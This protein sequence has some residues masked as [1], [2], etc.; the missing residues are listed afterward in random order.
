MGTDRL[1]NHYPQ[2]SLI[3]MVILEQGLAGKYALWLDGSEP[4][5][6]VVRHL[7]M[8]PQLDELQ[9]PEELRR[10]YELLDYRSRL[11]MSKGELWRHLLPAYIENELLCRETQ[12]EEIKAFV[13]K[14]PGISAAKSILT[15]GPRSAL[16]RKRETYTQ[17]IILCDG[18]DLSAA[19]AAVSGLPK[20]L[21]FGLSEPEHFDD[22]IRFE[23]ECREFLLE[24]TETWYRSG[25]YEELL[26]RTEAESYRILP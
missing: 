24:I 1:F 15:A 10:K 12:P 16:E 14:P 23:R 6:Y 18:N 19:R 5:A 26:A 13:L 20:E 11:K 4:A 25:E 22:Y 7:T 9:I 21:Y 2:Q 8:R 3:P 17:I